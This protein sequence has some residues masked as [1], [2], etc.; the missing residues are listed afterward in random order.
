MISHYPDGSV[1]I[2]AWKTKADS[3]RRSSATLAFKLLRKTVRHLFH[4]MHK[5]YTMIF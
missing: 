3:R 2:F 1:F 4:L 5:K